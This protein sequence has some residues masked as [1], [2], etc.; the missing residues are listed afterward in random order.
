M[1]EKYNSHH[2][3]FGAERSRHGIGQTPARSAKNRY[4][5]GTVKVGDK[6]QIVIPK[7]ARDTFGI[8]PG[9]TLLVLGDDENGLIVT[10]PE[11]VSEMASRIFKSIDST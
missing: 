1:L 6:G 8:H 5:F 2:A 4:V 11:I 7:E 3:P 9:D 10:R